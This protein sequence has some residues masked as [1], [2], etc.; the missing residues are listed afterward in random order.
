MRRAKKGVSCKVAPVPLA[1]KAC[2]GIQRGRRARRRRA[3]TLLRPVHP[4]HPSG[5]SALFGPIDPAEIEARCRREATRL[6]ACGKLKG[7]SAGD[8]EQ[9]GPV[10]MGPAVSAKSTPAC[11]KHA[12]NFWRRAARRRDP[13]DRSPLR[14]GERTQEHLVPHASLRSARVPARFTPHF[15]NRFCRVR[16]VRWARR[17]P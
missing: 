9:K 8:G 12:T 1:A 11:Q 3:V 13:L 10:Q 14:Y 16:Q 15:S 7:V 6:G 5:T 2:T 4:L 17:D